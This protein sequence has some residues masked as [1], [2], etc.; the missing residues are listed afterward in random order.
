MKFIRNQTLKHFNTLRLV[1]VTNYFC[2]LMQ[3]SDLNSIA[4]FI[5]CHKLP[6]LVLGGGSNLILPEYYSGVVIH[7]KLTGI[8]LVETT[9]QH[10]VVRVMAGVVWDQFVLHSLEQSWFGLENLSLIPGTV[11][12]S[13]I[14]NIGA[15]GIE[16]KDL[17]VNVDVFD[18][19]SEKFITFSADECGFSY[20]N[21]RFKT[22]TNYIVIAVTFRLYK[23]PN[24]QVNYGDVKQYADKYVNLTSLNLRD[25]IIQIRQSKLPDPQVIGNVGSF[26]H[27]PII[28]SSE[29]QELLIAYPQIKYFPVNDTQV[30]ISAG[31]LIENLGL[32]GY[33]QDNI[34]VY[35][36][37]AL[38]LVNYA[39]GT[40]NEI[41]QFAHFIQQQVWLKYAIQLNIEPIIVK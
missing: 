26:F 14:Q 7:N 11:G 15:Y 12:A 1:S 33:R 32:K 35:Q 8:Q 10:Y 30:K 25:I 31:W 17:I 16:V 28:A 4:Q 36:H 24:L 13:P 19:L 22:Q 6:Y 2:D 39:N 38:V 5:T 34:G 18:L 20:R 41:L 29:L 21:S 3:V 40:Q 37:Q 27:N 23:Q 9:L